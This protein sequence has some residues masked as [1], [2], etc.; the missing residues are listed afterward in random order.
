[1]PLPRALRPRR[2]GLVL[3]GLLVVTVFA[4]SL[5]AGFTATR[6]ELGAAIAFLIHGRSVTQFNP[7]SQRI[8]SEARTTATDDQAQEVTELADGKIMVANRETGVVQVYDTGS[9]TPQ[10]PSIDNADTA[11]VLA[12]GS[13]A[14]VLDPADD[15]VRALDAEGRVTSEVKV[16][17]ASGKAVPDG[18]DGI[19]VLA[20]DGRVTH[21]AA[22]KA[23]QPTS[24][25]DH[26]T[27]LAFADGRPVA[28]TKAGNAFDIAANPPHELPQPPV[29][30]GEKVLP[31]ST[32]GSGRYLVLL[33]QDGKLASYDPRTGAEREITDLPSGS[34][35][36]LGA[37]VVLGDRV[38]VPDYAAH[39]LYVRDLTTGTRLPDVTVPGE[40]KWFDLSVQNG[41][42]WA[43][44]PFDRR[45]VQIGADGMSKV[46]DLGD[47][48]GVKTD[49]TEPTKPDKPATQEQKPDPPVPPVVPVPTSEPTTPPT[50]S[51][52][53][54]PPPTTQPPT[55]QQVAVP[56][57]INRRSGPGCDTIRSAS[58]VCASPQPMPTPGANWGD[59]D[60]IADQNP[61]AQTLV[62]TGSTVTVRFWEYLKMPPLR[63]DAA[64][65]CSNITTQSS[66]QVRCDA[67]PGSG[68]GT[69]GTVESQDP[70]AGS[71]V[72]IGGR[73]V[74]TYYPTP[75]PPPTVPNVVGM[76]PAAACDTLPPTYV[77]K[78]VPDRIAR[79]TNVT[80][81]NPPAGTP[82]PAGAEVEVHFSPY[83]ASQLVRLKHRT[84]DVYILRF[85]VAS[86]GEYTVA[87]PLG[88][89][90]RPGA[91]A[92]PGSLQLKGFV[93][94]ANPTTCGGYAPNHYYSNKDTADVA[95]YVRS[96]NVAAVLIRPNGGSCVPG[97]RL[98]SRWRK[99]TNGQRLYTVAEGAPSPDWTN[100]ES[101]IGC[102]LA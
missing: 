10:G 20:D 33:G 27:A 83:Q 6:T 2:G 84:N 55:T 9:M 21:I 44:D 75:T 51:T 40:H 78:Q 4:A 101:G 72:H 7:E 16:P 79:D 30:A 45:S 58:L 82:H 37:P 96:P 73:V 13:A 54:T 12:S 77:C 26:V 69:P 23:D 98:L 29:P 59:L 57:V 67:V 14:Y 49:T 48:E 93:C 86:E 60:V 47:G 8:E 28:I 11:L 46:V 100:V 53:T 99:T 66:G 17:G 50:T 76:S 70:P 1:M 91:A 65:A 74:L 18:G 34:G 15:I 19:W 22:G 62:D 56:P 43:N 38:F 94:T 63:G 35:H 36:D 3:T 25:R 39:K 102:V 64:T 24:L 32:K 5:G 92:P 61:P 68:T 42:V 81:Q 31:A 88:Y 89:A 90:Y 52:P 87:E 97:Q 85:D 41:R 71:D 95:G 80:D